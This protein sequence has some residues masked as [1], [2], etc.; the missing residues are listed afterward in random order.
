MAARFAQMN[1]LV[2]STDSVH[3]TKGAIH[4]AIADPWGKRGGGYDWTG[5]LYM[6]QLNIDLFLQLLETPL[7]EV[8]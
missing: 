3:R 1:F 7:R 6:D 8:S 2:M 5:T 4:E